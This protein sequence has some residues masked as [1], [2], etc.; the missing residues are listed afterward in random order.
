MNK[1]RGQ[2]NLQKMVLYKGENIQN[3]TR[4]TR[5]DKKQ[6]NIAH[7]DPIFFYTHSFLFISFIRSS[8]ITD[9]I[10]FISVRR[11]QT[12]LLRINR[13]L[14]VLTKGIQVGGGAATSMVQTS[15]PCPNLDKSKEVV[16]LG[17]AITVTQCWV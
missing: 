17:G 11:L 16:I 2:N 14:D 9:Q 1:T 12:L 6:I 13:C 5:K 8:L 4:K 3:N 7:P 15:Q 10:N